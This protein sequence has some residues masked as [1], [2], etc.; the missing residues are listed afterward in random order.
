MG[1]ENLTNEEIFDYGFIL[2]FVQKTLENYYKS[3]SS[4]IVL[5]N[6]NRKG[7]IDCFHSHIIVRKPNDIKEYYSDKIKRDK[8]DNS[9]S[10]SDLFDNIDYENNDCIYDLISNF[11]LSLHYSEE[12]KNLFKAFDLIESIQNH[13]I[14]SS[15]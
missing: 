4:T 10:K 3:F 11:E 1:L 15:S 2:Q 6:D 9:S 5:N 12:N 8:D 7:S 13:I 14:K